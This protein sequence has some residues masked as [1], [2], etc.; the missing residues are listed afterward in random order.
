MAKIEQSLPTQTR[1]HYQKESPFQ[2]ILSG[3]KGRKSYG[4]HVLAVLRELKLPVQSEPMHNPC[5]A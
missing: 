3:G 4:V 1:G 2:T 5:M